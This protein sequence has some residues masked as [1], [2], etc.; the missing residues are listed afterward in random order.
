MLFKLCLKLIKKIF[1]I[2]DNNVN[3]MFDKIIN[4]YKNI[5][6]KKMGDLKLD[7]KNIVSYVDSFT[8][9]VNNF[10]NLDDETYYNDNMPTNLI[11]E[12][13][14]NHIFKHFNNY[15]TMTK[16]LLLKN[17]FVVCDKNEN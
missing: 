8:E 6:D 14:Q 5:I 10:F 3:I 1:L 12:K 4:E 7:L 13:I 9:N 17:L 2:D 15:D 16:T 11:C